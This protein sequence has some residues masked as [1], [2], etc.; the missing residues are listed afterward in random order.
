MKKLSKTYSKFIFRDKK[1]LKFCAIIVAIILIFCKIGIITPTEDYYMWYFKN[2]HSEFESIV[3]YVTENDLSVNI[4][5]LCEADII[6]SNSVK[7]KII[8]IMV[9]GDFEAIIGDSGFLTFRCNNL[10]GSKGEPIAIVYSKNHSEDVWSDL[11]WGP[12]DSYIQSGYTYKKIVS[13]WYYEF[14]SY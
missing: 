8:K 11:T 10:F 13:K 9:C 12:G 14:K 5:G 7:N 6:E 3:D 1:I 4:T 2:N